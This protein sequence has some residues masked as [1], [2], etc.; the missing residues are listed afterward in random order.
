MKHCTC[1]VVFHVAMFSSTRS[2]FY[3]DDMK[4]VRVQDSC[5]RLSQSVCKFYE[6]RNFCNVVLT[7]NRLQNLLSTTAFQKKLILVLIITVWALSI[8]LS[9]RKNAGLNTVNQ[10]N[11]ECPGRQFRHG[12]FL[13]YM[14]TTVRHLPLKVAVFSAIYTTQASTLGQPYHT[15]P[16]PERH[17]VPRREQ[18][19]GPAAPNGPV[20]AVLL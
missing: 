17:I 5:G 18:L 10:F 9:C 11:T 19:R 20:G 2:K 15:V 8:L 6:N 4:C 12:F 1:T 13:L 16:V 14:N 3:R 7:L